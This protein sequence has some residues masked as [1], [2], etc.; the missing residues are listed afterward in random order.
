MVG[1]RAVRVDVLSMM[2]RVGAGYEDGD[3]EYGPAIGKEPEVPC[4][5]AMTLR[6]MYDRSPLIVTSRLT[7]HV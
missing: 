2:Y 1:S 5:V 4:S 7:A 3:I 6:N